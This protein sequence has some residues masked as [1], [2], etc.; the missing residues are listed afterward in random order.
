MSR[1]ISTF[2]LFF[3]IVFLFNFCKQ[4][5][6]YSDY[7]IIPH[8]PES[9]SDYYQADK[10]AGHFHIPSASREFD[11]P[12]HPNGKI[13]M[14]T[15]NIGCRNDQDSEIKKQGNLKRIVITGDSH[16][17]GVLNNS[18]SVAAHLKVFLS[19]DH[20][21][22]EFEVLNAG[23]GYYGPQN[24]LG[25]YKKFLPYKPDLYIVIVYTG[26]DYLDGLRIE[27]ENN[28]MENPERPHG[29]YDK[30][31][32]IDGLYSGF[33]GQ[34][35]NQLKF[36]DTYPLYVDTA[37]T[38]MKDN[39][40]KINKLCL[41]NNSEF[42]VLLLPSKI[43]TE[44]KTDQK[45]IDEVF[46]IMGFTNSHIETNRAVSI[47]LAEWLTQQNIQYIDLYDS[48]LQTN[49]ELFWKADYHVN[50]HGHY[51]MAIQIFQTGYL[52]N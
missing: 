16:T 7:F 5:A 26:N 37:L 12:E 28:R 21:D 42:L 38:I 18:E 46:N 1:Y 11:W 15:N 41:E 8:F 47:E 10:I 9:E 36:F 4:K 48:F 17:D 39:L 40:S 20:P 13:E 30:L 45:R 22:L 3:G 31:W 44:A 33:T 6:D 34:Y 35:L 27:A 24:Y 29:Y 43:D 14:K 25:I 52:S 50:H 23:N 19:K 49:E 32:E 51:L 2:L